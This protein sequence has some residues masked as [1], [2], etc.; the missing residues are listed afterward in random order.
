MDVR[1]LGFPLPLHVRSV[2]Y[3]EELMREFQL[4][5]LSGGPPDVPHRLVELVHEL[6]TDYDGFSDAPDAVRDDAI[7]RGE[8]TVD[9]HYRVPASLGPA[10]ARLD[11]ML[12][13]ADAFCRSGEALLTLAAPDDVV[14]LRR[15][16]LA[17][18]VRQL[19]GEAPSPFSAT[20]R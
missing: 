6:T 19:S 12:D 2:E 4:L 8:S 18:F 3:H 11:E 13:E 14:A 9:L 17:E 1:L 10:A 20:R 15:W 5:A 7:A 16:Q